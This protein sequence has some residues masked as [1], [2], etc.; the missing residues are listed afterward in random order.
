[1]I[2]LSEERLRDSLGGLEAADLETDVEEALEH[3]HHVYAPLFGYDL[4][5]QDEEDCHY[6]REDE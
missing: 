4:D 3:K 2:S 6:W 1:M 5:E